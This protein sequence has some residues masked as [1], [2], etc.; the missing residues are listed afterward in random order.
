MAYKE[1]TKS[2][3]LA[4]LEIL[5]DRMQLAKKD[6]QHYFNLKKGYEGEVMFDSLTEK[7]QCECLILNDLLLEVNNTTFQIDSLIIVQGKIHFYEVKNF[8]GDYYYESDKL[9]KKHKLEIINPLHQL[10]RSESLLRQL[11]LN[12]GFNLPIDASVVFIN[13]KFTLYQLPLDKPIIFPTQIKSY[14]ANLNATPS[15]LTKKHKKLADQLLALHMTESPYEKLPSY[16]YDQLQ[17]GIICPNCHSFSATIGL[18]HYKCT[19]CQHKE[20]LDEAV[21]RSIKEFKLLFPNKK[22]TTKTIHNWC[23]VVPERRIRNI[24][25]RKFTKIGEHRWSYFE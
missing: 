8:E 17:K 11:L 6:K 7:L 20:L 12:H 2:K 19:K 21:L 15:K 14:L 23:Q 9:Y 3:E 25:L 24:L 18:K 5:N 1:R 10:S 13:P 16:S 22:L 4:I